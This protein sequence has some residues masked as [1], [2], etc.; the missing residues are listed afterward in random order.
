MSVSCRFWIHHEK[1]EFGLVGPLAR[2]E[3]KRGND[4]FNLGESASAKRPIN[5]SPREIAIM[6]LKGF[7]LLQC[8]IVLFYRINPTIA[9]PPLP[10]TPRQLSDLPEDNWQK[11]VRA[12]KSKDIKPVKIVSYK[13]NVTNPNG[14]LTGEGTILTRKAT[15]GGNATAAGRPIIE[16]P[17]EIV[18]DF[19]LNHPGFLSIDFGGA[20]N[21]TPGYPGI[22][23]AFS[24]TLQFLTNVSDFSRSDNGEEPEDKITPGSDQIAVKSKPY[25]WK[26]IHGCEFDRKVCTDGLHG[27]RYMKIYLDALP[28]DVPVTTSLGS[29]TITGLSLEYSGFLGTP[30]TFI[31]WIETSDENLNQ[32]WYDS[33]YT[34]EITTDVFRRFDTEPRQANSST[35]IDKLVL[36]DGAKRDRD[37]YVG[38]VAVSGKTTY[39]THDTAIAAR[40]VLAD[41]ADH[42]RADGWIPPASIRLYDLPLM[43]YPLWWVVCSYD[44]YMYTGDVAYMTS[45]Y[46]NMVLVLDK[47]YPSVTNQDTKL[48]QKGIGGSDGYGDY[49]FLPRT[50]PIT[51][52]NALYVMALSN[53]ATIA[54]TL[55]KSDDARRWIDRSKVV[56]SAISERLFDTSVGAFYDG[57]CGSSPCPTHAQD[58]NSISVL[59]GAATPEQAKLAL[60]YLAKNNARP[61]GNSF[62]DNDFLQ[63][64]FSQ[65]VYAFI[66]YFEIQARFMVKSPDTAL[67]EIRRLY[68]WMATHDPQVTVWEGIGTNGSLYEDGFSSQAHGW[69]TGIVPLLTNNILGVL[70][71]GPGFRTWSIKPIPGDVKWAKGVVPTPSGPITVR[72][73]RDDSLGIFWLIASAPANTRGTI[74]LPVPSSSTKVYLNKVEVTSASIA[75]TGDGYA[76]ISVEGGD[77]TITVGYN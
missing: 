53:A 76:T 73:H 1:S 8:L 26:N 17:P 24:E 32:W 63:D 37:P 12:P 47:Y 72:W 50:G 9:A 61:Y 71:T 62:Y 69:A 19:G 77:H 28:A 18:V 7:L 29:V 55:G 57:S 16:A 30:D 36:H 66:S 65:R 34:N 59:S 70:P 39:L 75:S 54:T 49:A 23:L 4:I 74:S 58:G 68:G 20:A 2:G 13:G 21:F 56:A 35:L 22:R 51:Y 10:N 60:D 3:Y 11:Y 48:I 6:F 43:D 67:E 33:S 5:L 15:A 38:D 42:Q 52:Y 25:T 64:G 31:G 44:L 14:L 46:K 27:F 45:Y 41:L 40:N